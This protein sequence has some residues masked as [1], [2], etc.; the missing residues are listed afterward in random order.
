MQEFDLA[1]ENATCDK[2]IL[3]FLGFNDVVAFKYNDEFEQSESVIM[4]KMTEP[5]A[6]FE[7]LLAMAGA[8]TKRIIPGIKYLL[9]RI[10][11]NGISICIVAKQFRK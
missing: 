6:N 2:D 8:C 3:V 11:C 9:E 1:K 10:A 5:G 4:Q 7:A